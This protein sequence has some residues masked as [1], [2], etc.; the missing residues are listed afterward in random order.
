LQLTQEKQSTERQV[1][2]VMSNGQDGYYETQIK[3][4]EDN[5]NRTTRE[6]QQIQVELAKLEEENILHDNK[7]KMIINSLKHDYETE[8]QYQG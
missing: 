6:T 5:L 4:Y 7:T 3:E 8:Y 1:N 2:D